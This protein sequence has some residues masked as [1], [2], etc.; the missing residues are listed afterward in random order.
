MHGNAWQH[1]GA[2]PARNG[3]AAAWQGAP[4]H[5]WMPDSHH[6]SWS[7]RYEP[8]LHFSTC[9]HMESGEQEWLMNVLVGP[10]G[11][12]LDAACKARMPCGYAGTRPGGAAV[13]AAAPCP[14]AAARPGA[15][16]GPQNPRP[17]ARLHCQHV[18]AAR[19]QQLGHIK[20][21]GQ[22]AVLAVSH[23]LQGGRVRG[24]GRNQA[25][26][27]SCGG[28]EAGG[29]AELDM[30]LSGPCPLQAAWTARPS[31]A[32]LHMPSIPPGH[33]ASSRR[34]SPRLRTPGTLCNKG[35]QPE[36]ACAASGAGSSSA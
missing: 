14:A 8:S 10:G 19:P 18:V 26:S 32:A 23:K 34:P 28:A 2:T 33:S 20:L 4:T 24:A 29:M 22:P 16:A 9:M 1:A 17:S 12:L 31:A 7:S 5:L 25:W 3:P 11:H 35:G 6:M 27:S 30:L 21:S 36:E 15:A 13:A